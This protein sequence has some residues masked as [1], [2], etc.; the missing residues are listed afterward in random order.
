MDALELIR[1]EPRDR[2]RLNLRA[3]VRRRSGLQWLDLARV[4]QGNRAMFDIKEDDGK[5]ARLDNPFPVAK[6]DK[7]AAIVHREQL[8]LCLMTFPGKGYPELGQLDLHVVHLPCPARLPSVEER[9][10]RGIQSFHR[11][12]TSALPQRKSA[13]SAPCPLVALEISPAQ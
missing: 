1:V 3:G 12:S 5:L 13:S 2:A 11:K 8:I 6:R 10:K 9:A 7:Q 4:G